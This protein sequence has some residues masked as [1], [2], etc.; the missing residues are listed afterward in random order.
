MEPV[1]NPHSICSLKKMDKVKLK[2]ETNNTV[3]GAGM[4]K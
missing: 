4:G 2:E 3:S 1:R